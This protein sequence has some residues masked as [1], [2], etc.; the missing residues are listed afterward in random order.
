MRFKAI[1]CSAIVSFGLFFYPG[2]SMRPADAQMSCIGSPNP[3]TCWRCQQQCENIYLKEV[4]G[5]HYN[6][7]TAPKYW[8]QYIKCMNGCTAFPTNCKHCRYV[9]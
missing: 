1:I 7:T 6:P 8:K 3:W 5:P 4:N 9:Q 2:I